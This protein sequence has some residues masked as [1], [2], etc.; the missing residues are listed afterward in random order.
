[1]HKDYPGITPDKDHEVRGMYVT[2]LTDAHM[3]HLD[4]FEGTEY[5]RQAVKVRLLSKVGDDKGR[6]NVEGEEVEGE[7]YVFNNTTELED[8]EWD[9]EEFRTQKMK[10][11][12][13]E[14]YGFED[15]DRFSPQIDNEDVKEAAVCESMTPSLTKFVPYALCL[16]L[17]RTETRNLS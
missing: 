7:V 4:V 8:R 1:M 15:S 6:G 2:G 11:W 16:I 9:F 12:T 14:D 13:R 17:N 10:K 5:E 3:F